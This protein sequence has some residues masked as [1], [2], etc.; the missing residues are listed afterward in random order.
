ME[1]VFKVGV[2]GTSW[3]ARIPL[4][5]IQSYRRTEVVAIASA[6][7]ERAQEAA[8]KFGADRAFDD[9]R[10][11]VRLPDLDIV[12]VGGPVHLHHP[13]AIAALEEG[14]HVLCEKPLGVNVAEA[15]EMLDLAERDGLR[16]AIAFTMRHYPWA[17]AIKQLIDDGFLGQLRHVNI[18]WFMGPRRHSAGRQRRRRTGPKPRRALEMV[19]RRE[20]GRRH[21]RRD[22]VPLHRSHAPLLRRVQRRLGV[23]SH[24]A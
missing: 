3:A 7:I 9:Y 15:R 19:Q 4:P 8:E 22:G 10:E 2:I 14:K 16:H 13:M 6:R 18:A 23:D 20:P 5:T 21:A 24:M 17:F 1:K 11:M 12:Y